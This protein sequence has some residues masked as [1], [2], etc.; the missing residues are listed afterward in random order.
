MT[1]STPKIGSALQIHQK[2]IIL[3]AKFIEMELLH[4]SFKEPSSLSGTRRVPFCGSME[5]VLCLTA[6][7]YNHACPLLAPRSYGR[8]TACARPDWHWW[9]TFTSTLGSL[10]NETNA[11]SFPHLFFS[12]VLSQI[13]A[14]KFCP[15]YIW[16]MLEATKNPQRMCSHNVLW[17]C[18]KCQDSWLCTSLLT[19]LMNA[20]IPWGYPLHMN[21]SSSSWSILFWH[22]QAVTPIYLN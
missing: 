8:S 13:L 20:Q 12:S 9:P 18:S 16:I 19:L 3:G 22:G 7:I 17:K 4:S 10:R 21:R 6:F 1:L 14:I 2:T 11:V 5:N 15:I